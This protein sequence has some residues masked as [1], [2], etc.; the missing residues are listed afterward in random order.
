MRILAR[1]VTSLVCLKETVFQVCHNRQLLEDIGGLL[2]V[3]NDAGCA[4]SNFLDDAI[5]DCAKC[6]LF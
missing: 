3:T 2:G 4:P 6:L 1:S 5:L